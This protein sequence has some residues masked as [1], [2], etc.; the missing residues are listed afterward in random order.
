MY[1]DKVLHFSEPRFPILEWETHNDTSHTELFLE[2]EEEY[3]LAPVSVTWGS[4]LPHLPPHCPSQNEEGRE[5]KCQ[6]PTRKASP[7]P[8]QFP[9]GAFLIPSTLEGSV[10]ENPK[11]L[12][13]GPN[14]NQNSRV[15]NRTTLLSSSEK[16]KRQLA[17]KG[18]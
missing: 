16:G 3:Q 5:A 8:T 2:N 10:W 17:E 15:I 11:H 9:M 13:D 12:H 14:P 18:N 6:P 7:P 4:P 1:L